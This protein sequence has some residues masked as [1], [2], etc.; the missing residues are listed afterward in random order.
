MPTSIY[1]V[2]CT[3]PIPESRLDQKSVTC[4]KEHATQL[5]NLRRQKR[6]RVKCRLCGIPSTAEERKLFAQWRREIGL[7]K[8]RGKPEKIPEHVSDDQV[9]WY[10]DNIRDGGIR[11]ICLELLKARE[12]KHAKANEANQS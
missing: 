5:K 7:A 12:E 9:R 4:S 8:G 6:D 1:C 3:A 2:I 10:L 11:S